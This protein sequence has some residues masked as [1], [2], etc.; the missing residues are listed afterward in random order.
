VIWNAEVLPAYLDAYGSPEGY[1]LLPLRAGML[2]CCVEMA[3][4]PALVF[5]RQ[6]PNDEMWYVLFSELRRLMK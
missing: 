4:R 3:T 6:H 2:I 5:K 1:N